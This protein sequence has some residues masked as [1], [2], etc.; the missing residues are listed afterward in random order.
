MMRQSGSAPPETDGWACQRH[1][2]R[3][4]RSDAGQSQ[5]RPAHGIGERLS[6]RQR[7]TPSL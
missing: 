1:G 6:N 2:G 3:S 7:A 4:D 5:R